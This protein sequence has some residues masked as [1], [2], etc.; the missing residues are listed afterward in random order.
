MSFC[1]RTWEGFQQRLL[2]SFCGHSD[3]D[4]ALPEWNDLTMKSGKNNH[5]CDKL[6]RLALELGYTCNVVKD[7][8]RVGI[9][10]DLRNA[11]ALKTPL[12]NDYVKYINLLHQTGY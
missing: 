11:C 12:P 4:R 1:V 7:K 10:T 6:I 3:Q 2:S 5:Y 9:T 8:V